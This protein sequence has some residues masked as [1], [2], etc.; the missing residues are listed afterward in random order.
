[1]LLGR[2]A[3]PSNE[4]LVEPRVTSLLAMLDTSADAPVGSAVEEG[5]GS[6]GA[7]S[8]FAQ[9]AS[10]RSNQPKPGT[11]ARFV[12]VDRHPVKLKATTRVADAY[13][14]F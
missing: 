14:N 6:P 8:Y 4:R 2:V 11:L 13:T 12:A 3:E 7:G 5:R 1:M 9:P 10:P